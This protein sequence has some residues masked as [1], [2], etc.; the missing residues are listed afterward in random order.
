MKLS[1]LFLRFLMFPFVW[2]VLLRFLSEDSSSSSSSLII[3]DEEVE[4]LVDSSIGGDPVLLA[5]FLVK[6]DDRSIVDVEVF[7]VVACKNR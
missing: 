1:E 5:D 7:V 4:V 3:E 2:F 6:F